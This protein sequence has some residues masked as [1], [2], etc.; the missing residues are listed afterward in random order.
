MG[1]FYKI[2]KLL[3]F[4]LSGHFLPRTRHVPGW[5]KKKLT[6]EKQK[7]LPMESQI[8]LASISV[9]FSSQ[10]T[11]FPSSETLNIGSLKVCC[12]KVT[13]LSLSALLS[14][15]KSVWPKAASNQNKKRRF[16]QQKTKT[17]CETFLMLNKQKPSAVHLFSKRGGNKEQKNLSLS[18]WS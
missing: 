17:K 9:K 6:S 13:R 14:K 10:M 8:T 18:V 11:A 4:D 2:R 7:S 1:N 3:I 15:L 5:W 12:F 16:S